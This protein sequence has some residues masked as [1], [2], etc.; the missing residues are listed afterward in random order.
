MRYFDSGLFLGNG[1]YST[2]RVKLLHTLLDR[3]IDGLNA[4]QQ[5][6]FH[7][8]RK[9]HE[10]VDELIDD[11]ALDIATAL[12]GKNVTV[13]RRLRRNQRGKIYTEYRD[14]KTKQPVAFSQP[15]FWGDPVE[16]V[17]NDEIRDLLTV[18][19]EKDRT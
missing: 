16:V 2:A 7:L 8:S 6:P 10:K 18:A 5:A 1:E 19:F 17:S 4:V 15:G 13:G 11:I 14:A 3:A 9:T 12:T